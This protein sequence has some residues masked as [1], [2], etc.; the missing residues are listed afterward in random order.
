MN[1]PQTDEP[2]DDAREVERIRN[3][4]REVG[5][6][7]VI[8]GLGGILLPGPVGSPFLVLG[9]LVLWPR[10]FERV[11]LCM[12]KRFPKLHHQ[13]LRQV[14]RFLADLDRRY[15]LAR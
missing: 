9:G 14:K 12:E 15:P 2:I 11:E 4:P 5:V 8:V 6:L 3:L 1:G 10:T 7:L 13:S